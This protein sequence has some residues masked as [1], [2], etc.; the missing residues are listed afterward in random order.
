MKIDIKQIDTRNNAGNE[1]ENT[2]IKIVNY[3][4]FPSDCVKSIY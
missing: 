1:L 4:S 3:F 2:N